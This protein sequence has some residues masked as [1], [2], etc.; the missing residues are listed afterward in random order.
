MAPSAWAVA[1]AFAGLLAALA[2]FAPASWLAAAV[3]RASNSRIVLNDPR[4]TVWQG[5]AQLVLTA[6]PGS[7]DTAALP[8]RLAW[9]LRPR[10][11]G[12]SLRL[13]AACCTPRPIEATLQWRPGRMQ[14]NVGDSDLRWPAAL[15]SGLGTPWNTLQLDGELRMTSRALSVEWSAGRLA[16][17]GQAELVAQ[18]ISSRLSTL[19]PMGSY[20]ITL[21]GGAAPAVRLQTLEGS[22]QLTGGGQWVGQRLHFQGEASAAADREAALSNLLNII[23]RRSGPR[24]IITIG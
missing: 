16:L 23:G 7:T 2:A 14:L 4:G 8:D 15:L 12:L 17:N 11:D 21:Q 10:W 5:S 20:R 24:S 18:D 3:Q 13:G 22:L 1:G 6:G 19:R 9:S